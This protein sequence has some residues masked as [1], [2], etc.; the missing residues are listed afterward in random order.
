MNKHILL[1][2]RWLKDKDSVSQKEL[3]ENSRDNR[4]AVGGAAD[5]AYY[6]NYIAAA[7]WV[8]EYFL[9]YPGEDRAQYKKELNK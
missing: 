9:L 3:R 6:D 8:K 7:Y 2:M 4:G 1:V 5:A